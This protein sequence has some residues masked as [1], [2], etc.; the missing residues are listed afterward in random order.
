MVCLPQHT[1]TTSIPGEL[2]PCGKQVQLMVHEEA[3][4]GSVVGTALDVENSLPTR[5]VHAH[6]T[7][8]G[9]AAVEMVLNDGK[10]EGEA[11]DAAAA[12]HVCG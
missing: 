8:V 10:L 9:V 1:A 7:D 3:Q 2:Q 4:R 12:A 6:L 11:I 5:R